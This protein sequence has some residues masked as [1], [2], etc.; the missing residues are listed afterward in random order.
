MCSLILLGVLVLL[1]VL[2]LRRRR[3]TVRFVY[4]VGPV[5]TKKGV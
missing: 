1:V 5:R 3:R 4:N 2:V